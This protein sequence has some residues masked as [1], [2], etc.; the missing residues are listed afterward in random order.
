MNL[1]ASL[2]EKLIILKILKQIKEKWLKL[3]NFKLNDIIED[4]EK[5]LVPSFENVVFLNFHFEHTTNFQ[6]FGDK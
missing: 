2:K 5:I 1:K 6:S 4:P 3:K